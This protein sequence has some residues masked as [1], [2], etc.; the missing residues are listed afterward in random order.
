MVFNQLPP[1]PPGPRP[2]S[3][4]ASAADQWPEFT[5]DELN[6]GAQCQRLSAELAAALGSDWSPVPAADDNVV[7]IRFERGD[8]IFVVV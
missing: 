5:A 3:Q 7:R 4:R 1:E 8:L 2:P 6:D